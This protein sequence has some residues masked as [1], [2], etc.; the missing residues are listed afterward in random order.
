MDNVSSSA[1][2]IVAVFSVTCLWNFFPRNQINVSNKKY[3]RM[4]LKA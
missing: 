1:P 2:E 4:M 3:G